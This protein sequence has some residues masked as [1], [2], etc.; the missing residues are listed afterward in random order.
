[1]AGVVVMSVHHHLPKDPRLPYLRLIQWIL[2]YVP[3][4]TAQDWRDEVTLREHVCYPKDPVHAYA[5]LRDLLP[6]MRSALPKITTPVLLIYSRADGSVPASE[7]HAET[8]LSDLGSA[9]KN[10]FWLEKSGH[11]IPSD[12]ERETAF[13]AI[14]DFIERVSQ[15]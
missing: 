13:T 10:L 15:R 7:G 1:M 2:P 8:I 14:T 6:I 3:K 4:Q 12:L 5:E 11:V 9:D